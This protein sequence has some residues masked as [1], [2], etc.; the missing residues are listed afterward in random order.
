L[1]SWSL[2]GLTSL[3][4]TVGVAA[5]VWHC[6]RPRLPAVGVVEESADTIVAVLDAAGDEA[7]VTVT[8]LVA[9]ATCEQ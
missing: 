9:T 2:A 6:A 1:P 5:I 3:A 4:L 8:Q 7:A